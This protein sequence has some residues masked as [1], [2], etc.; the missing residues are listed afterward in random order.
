MTPLSAFRHV[1]NGSFV[2]FFTANIAAAAP[3]TWNVDAA[4]SWATA[5]SWAAGIPGATAG[6]SSTDI[7]TFSYP[8]TL[9]RVVT[10]D[11]NRNIGGITFSNPSSSKFT[12]SGGSLLLSNG[13][14]IQTTVD[15][16]DHTDTISS[17]IGLVFTI[18]LGVVLIPVYG[19][20]GAGIS[21]TVSYTF[22]T[23]YQFI[24]FSRMTKLR[25]RDFMLTR[26]EI[27]LLVSEVKKMRNP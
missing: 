12:L 26:H 27:R 8:I 25:L 17:A 1:R 11:A 22:L 4:G 13:G 23:L 6:I 9:D 14:I 2:V 10:V 3:G 16:G 21:A 5:G 19:I 24:I 18:G 15:D 7:A 20:V